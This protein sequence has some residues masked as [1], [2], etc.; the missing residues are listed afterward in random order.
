MTPANGKIGGRQGR[1]PIFS[2]LSSIF[3]KGVKFAIRDG[4][5]ATEIIGVASED[6]RRIGAV[7]NGALYLRGLHFTVEG[8][9]THYFTK[10]GPLEADLGVAGGGA[11]GGVRVLEN[12]VNVSVSQISAMVGG[13][14][15]R[16]ADIVLQ[17]GA[18]SFN[19]RYGATPEEERTRVLDAARIRA[20][21]GA[22]LREQKK[23]LEG[24]SGSLVWTEKEKDELIAEG[25]VSGYDGFYA[26]PVEQHPEL[27]D[28]PFN[29][30][31]IRHVE[32]GR[33]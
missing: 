12:G 19:I 32:T 4:V 11:G 33:R 16:F 26:L 21:Q 18:L 6:S 8:R 5:V 1:R 10:A 14:M 28:S 29:I 24:E 20:V 31:L 25:R 30:H 3:G 27:A 17:Q 9:D 13:E 23:V 7:L 22:W 2:A 15:R